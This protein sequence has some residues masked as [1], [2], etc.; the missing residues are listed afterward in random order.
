[1]K[2]FKYKIEP[3]LKYIKHL[4]DR[5]LQEM[6][7]AESVVRKVEDNMSFLSKKIKK[8]YDKSSEI[9]KAIDDIRFINDNNFYLNSLKKKVVGLSEDLKVAEKVY[10]DKYEKLI[11]LQKKLKSIETHKEKSLLDYKKEYKKYQQ[12]MNDELNSVRHG[13]KNA[14]PV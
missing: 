10:K 5:A 14:K 9:G 3:Y 11:Q 12:K 1:M 13:G 8:A 2:K 7:D 6:K 4:R